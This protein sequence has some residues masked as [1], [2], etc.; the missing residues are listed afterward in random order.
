MR[1]NIIGPYSVIGER[2][3][4]LKK[5]DQMVRSDATKPDSS[6]YYLVCSHCLSF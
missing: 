3:V 5:V 4:V 1:Q 2:L 6:V